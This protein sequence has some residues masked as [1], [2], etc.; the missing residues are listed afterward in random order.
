MAHINEKQNV[1]P[2]SNIPKEEVY[3]NPKAWR[4]IVVKYQKPDLKKAIWQ[5]V[6]TIVPLLMCW[7]AMYFL[8]DI[9]YWLILPIALIAGGL[10]IR[11]FIIFHDCGHQSFFKSRKL[12]DIVGYFTG[13]ITFTPYRFWHWEHGIHHS[14]AGDLDRREEGDVWT[15]TVEEYEAASKGMKLAYRL[16]RNPLVLFTFI[17]L[18]L[19]LIWQR[20]S[21]KKAKMKDR[22]S[23]WWTNLGIAVMVTAGCLIMGWQKY[24]LLQLSVCVVS[25][26]GGVW[27]F[28]VQ[29][30]FEDVYWARR[31]E[32]N[33]AAAALE[34]SSYYKL[35]KIL[36]WFTGNIGFH[37]IHHLSSRIPNYNLE[38][39]HNAEPLF[40]Q[41]PSLTLRTG[42]KSAKLNLIDEENKRLVSFKYLKEYR[43]KKA[44]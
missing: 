9:S 13:V 32:W 28:Y 25:T 12:N 37:H 19:F 26:T 4:K 18:F 30:Q 17:P 27:M 29:H 31:D 24:L 42:F 43:A 14:T 35:P 34:G 15:M 38:E 23:V 7:A 40:Q 21:S 1:N 8:Y 33:F 16:A 10:V 22:R 5:I 20:I 39:C 6:N 41:V 44:A 2:E 11:T 36:Q 3:K